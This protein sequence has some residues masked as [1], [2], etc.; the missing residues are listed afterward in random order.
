[1][2]SGAA[3][4]PR[5]AKFGR[6]WVL[7][8]LIAAGCAGTAD[9]TG[10]PALVR[11]LTSDSAECGQGNMPVCEARVVRVDGRRVLGAHPL[12]IEPGRRRLTVF[13]R[14]NVGLMIGDA[15]DFEREIEADLVPGGRYRVEAR[16][17][18]APCTVSLA[19]DR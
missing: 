17:H 16:M 8:P 7:M 10:R 6:L 12:A 4:M 13:C 1:M 3:R 14:V 2:A 15:Q 5:A 19:E 11:E 18:P 9:T